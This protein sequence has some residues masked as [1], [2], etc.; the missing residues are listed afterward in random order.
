LRDVQGTDAL[1]I[2]RSGDVV[3]VLKAPYQFN[4]PAPDKVIAPSEF[5][6]Q[7]GYLPDEVDLDH[8]INMHGT[9]LAAG[10]AIAVGKTLTGVRAIDVAPTV[11]Y[12]LN[13]PG[14]TSARGR[15]LYDALANGDA[16]REVTIL[17]ISDFHGQLI[18][19]MASTD[20]FSADGARA[21][22][23]NVGGVAYLKPW[24]DLYRGEARD[25]AILVTAG[26]AIGA[27][28]PLSAFFDDLPTIEM[29][30]A[31]GF[32]ADGLGNHNFDVSADFL[33][34]TIMPQANYPFLS[35]NLVLSPNAAP[36]SIASPGATPNSETG[37]PWA[38][39]ARFEF[40]GVTLGLIGFTN[41]DLPSLTR[42]GALGPFMVAAPIPAVNAE[43]A[44]L[45]GEGV[46]V[47]VAM[48]HMGAVAGG[49]SDPIGP[50]IDLADNVTGVDV[51][52]GD[53]TDR[54]AIS[55][56]PNGVLF[57]EVLSKG[58]MINRVRI[59]VDTASGEV[60]YKTADHHRPWTM[61]ITPNPGIQ[62]ELADL[63]QA[64]EPILGEV[65]GSST[66]PITRA[67]SCGTEN[68]RTCESLEGNVVA[69]A[70]RYTYGADFA[71][72]NSGSLRAD[73]TCPKEDIPD[74]F[75]G[76]DVAPNSI[77][78]G[79]VLGVL[80]FGNVA[81]T[82]DVTGE[83]LKA[84]LE[85]AVAPMPA[86][87]GG[88]AQVSGFC[89]TYDIDRESGNRVTGAV[90]QED[91]GACSGEVV[92]FSASATYMLV[93]N[94]YL[95]AGGDRYPD[96]SAKATTRE[97]LDEIV[98][99]YVGGNSPFAVPGAPLEPS[100]QGRITCEGEGCPVPVDA[101]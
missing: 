10:P 48:G 36:V 80:P 34:G 78:R 95:V 8:S 13:V 17:D 44:K 32:D 99:A 4:S 84:M 63:N 25:G 81:V 9:F 98:A 15:I 30:N 66:V 28:P 87:A 19:L 61:G 71:I 14:P 60:V 57:T 90:R 52:I 3:V 51:V 83:E 40:N 93:T 39:S 54:A 88:F 6:G 37:T 43:A 2:G 45:R 41:D 85:A 53:H 23:A 72:V 11:A 64:I 12:L 92:D 86:A 91:D 94:D 68:G 35:A 49:F 67:D 24:L 55:T 75:C 46:P 18:P 74:D 7:H 31:L 56:R 38:P 22:S 50:G 101:P 82:L 42:P 77:T 70:I 20:S 27:T 1:N 26:D 29:M 69:D 47:V 58:V 76:P 33:T 73:M 21:G 5:F 96:L 100:I 59:V 16:L 62:A 79:Q 65:V 89:F 97:V